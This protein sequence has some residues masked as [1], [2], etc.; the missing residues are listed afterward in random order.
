[1]KHNGN[2]GLDNVIEIA[3]VMKLRSMAKELVGTM[4]EILG[5]CLF[6]GC[7]MYGND[8]KDLQTEIDEGEV[9]IPEE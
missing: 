8:P 3:R 5:T 9:E 2:I 1:M 7:T 4:K 6:V